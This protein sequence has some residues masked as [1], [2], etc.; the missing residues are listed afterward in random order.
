MILQ[1]K[2]RHSSMGGFHWYPDVAVT[3]LTPETRDFQSY[4][5][6]YPNKDH[7]DGRLL[8][9]F[10]NMLKCSLAPHDRRR[11]PCAFS[12]IIM[13]AAARVAILALAYITAEVNL[14]VRVRPEHREAM[15]PN[16]ARE[17]PWLTPRTPYILIDPV[18]VRD[19]GHPSSAG[20]PHSTH[21]SPA[22]HARRG[23]W[24]R[25]PEGFSKQKTWVRETFVGVMKWSSEGKAYKIIDSS[26]RSP[27]R[28]NAPR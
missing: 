27:E 14:T 13:S 24:R 11:S 2:H 19:Y 15:K 8:G 26:E 1:K 17:K 18:R 22:P 21:R 23:H 7:R 5:Y 16:V 25:L 6:D 4:L 3:P 28:A 12:D 9:R 10:C 20:D